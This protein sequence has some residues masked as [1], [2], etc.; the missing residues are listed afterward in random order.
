MEVLKHWNGF[1]AYIAYIAFL[2]A[3]GYPFQDENCKK[4][5]KSAKRQP[6]T[7]WAF[8]F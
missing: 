1:E 4:K 8:H 7:N 5:G 3:Y 2:T 6:M